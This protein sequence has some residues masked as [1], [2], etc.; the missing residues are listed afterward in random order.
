[1]NI[2]AVIFL[3]III[4]I[5]HWISP[6]NYIWSRDSISELAAQKYTYAWL[7][8]L[9]FIGFGSMIFI[10]SVWKVVNS[11]KRNWPHSLVAIYGL[12]ILISGI[13]PTAPITAGTLYSIRQ[14]EMHSLMATL[15]GISI[16]LAMLA[17]TFTDPLPGRKA[18]HLSALILTV[19]LSGSFAILGSIAG[20]LQRLLYLIGFAWLIFLEVPSLAFSTLWMRKMISEENPAKKP[21]MFDW[22]TRYYSV[23][24]SSHANALYCEQVYGKNLCQHGFAEMDHL[25]HM[26]KVAEIK[27]GDRVLDVGCGNGLITE[28]IADQTGANLTGIDFI[29]EAIQQA[30]RRTKF[31]RN[32]LDFDTMDMHQ[33]SFPEQSFDV[34]ISV[35]TLYFGDAYE[36]LHPM[37]PLLTPG[38]RLVAFF[39]QSAGPEVD[40]DTYP[41]ESIL[42]DGTD[43]AVALRRLN[44]MYQTW[45]YTEQMLMHL[46][47]RKPILEELKSQFELEGN[48][49]LY[50]NHLGEVEGIERAYTQGAGARFLYLVKMDR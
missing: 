24:A 21:E 31:K 10:G 9:G 46:R 45:D 16:S 1:M 40:L 23:V 26:I 48:L 37:I 15:A 22:Y 30:N 12:A 18:I 41:K 2:I 29:E 49:F 43:L 34:V 3:T 7:M 27:E 6:D 11:P 19:I 5:A 28:Y 39:D 38:G 20:V 35:D 42:P 4:L 44:L 50:E 8:R 33:L 13:F 32:W 14:S 36:I 47:K 25:D 17:F